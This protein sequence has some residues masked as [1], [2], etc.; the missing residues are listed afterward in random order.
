MIPSTCNFFYMPITSKF[1]I[2]APTSP[3][4]QDLYMLL[5]TQNL[6]LRKSNNNF[7][8][9]TTKTYILIYLSL[10]VLPRSKDD[11]TIYPITQTK[12]SK[13]HLLLLTSPHSLYTIQEKASFTM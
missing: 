12:S 6:W 11:N 3:Q 2:S 9:Y 10:T 7:I 1:I 4:V 13:N 5:P 8:F